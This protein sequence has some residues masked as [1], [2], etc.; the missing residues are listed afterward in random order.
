MYEFE[1]KFD[2]RNGCRPLTALTG[3][4]YSRC[5]GRDRSPHLCGEGAPERLGGRSRTGERKA[6]GGESRCAGLADRGAVG[7]VGN[8]QAAAWRRKPSRRVDAPSRRGGAPWLNDATRNGTCGGWQPHR[9][10]DL[11][12]GGSG[13]DAH[14]RPDPHR[15]QHAPQPALALALGRRVPGQEEGVEVHVLRSH[16]VAPAR[17]PL[18]RAGAS[19]AAQACPPRDPRP[20]HTRC[21]HAGGR[22]EMN[23]EARAE[24][25]EGGVH[26]LIAR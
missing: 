7:T 20:A 21:A 12:R 11:S 26:V 6:E 14:E 19:P 22:S 1:R 8:Q 2:D 18:R 24:P 4:A 10:A 25:K 13:E 5:A 15:T 17:L 9:P 3:R 23:S 16:R